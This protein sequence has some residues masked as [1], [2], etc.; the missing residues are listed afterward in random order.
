MGRPRRKLFSLACVVFLAC[1]SMLLGLLALGT[2]VRANHDTVDWSR[3]YDTTFSARFDIYPSSFV[4]DQGRLY[5]FHYDLNQGN[6][7]TNLTMDRYRMSTVTGLPQWEI[8]RVVNPTLP[9]VV[10]PTNWIGYPRPPSVAQDHDGNLYVAWADRAFNVYVSKSTDRGGSWGAPSRVDVTAA[11]A[12]DTGPVIAAAPSGTLYV[13][14]LQVWGPGNLW[15]LTAATSLDRAGTWTARTNLTASGSARPWTHEAAIDSQGRMHV[16]Y[17]ALGAESHVNHTWSDDGAAWAAPV[18][19]DGGFQGLWPAITV[20]SGDRVHVAWYD[21]RVSTNSVP[22]FWYRRSDDRGA[23]WSLELPITQ[24]RFVVGF[25]SYAH[26]VTYG[27]TVLVGYTAYNGITT[28]FAYVTSSDGGNL[29]DPEKFVPGNTLLDPRFSV[30]RNGTLYAS[31]W[32]WNEFLSSYEVGYL[33]W[34]GPPSAPVIT[35]IARGT[36]DLTV[37]W[38]ASPEADV[39]AYRVWRSTDGVTYELLATVDDATTSYANTGLSNGTYWYRVTAIDG[40]GTPSHSSDPMSGTVGQ[41]VEEMVDDLEAQIDAVL[42]DLANAQ[43][44]I[45]DLQARL[46]QLQTDLGSL[47]SDVDANDAATQQR[48]NDLE[49]QLDSL[50]NQLDRMRSEVATQ[51]MSYVNM[52][53]VIIVL[54]LVAYLLV[55]QMRMPRM[56]PARSELVPPPRM[57][58]MSP[59]PKPPAESPPPPPRMPEDDL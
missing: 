15:N 30:D 54:A 41:T 38:S 10:R 28:S 26:I 49:D 48:L 20:D 50:Q 51:T 3:Y 40:R 1:A 14:W 22:T 55:Q 52:L 57:E 29:W 21:S 47:Q 34:D 18:Q 42:A 8:S 9:N 16:A 23:S 5:L 7:D 39:I 35:G 31:V 25:G 11:E 43:T 27:T 17:W 19:L 13:V 6:G 46:T 24:G 44:D 12:F 59:S 33:I 36:S 56:P 58:P 53:L 32:H 4:D 2:P 45:D 37:S